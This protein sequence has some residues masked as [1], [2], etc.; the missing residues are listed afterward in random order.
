MKRRQF[1]GLAA[2]VGSTLA[3]AGCLGD[4]SN[5]DTGSDT[6]TGPTDDATATAPPSPTPTATPVDPGRGIYIQSFRERMSMQGTAASGDYEFALMFT[7]PHDFWTVTGDEVSETTIEDGDSVHLMAAVWDP[8]TGTVLPD[9][10]LSVEIA[11]D[12][13]LVSQE[14][15][16]PMLSQPMGFHY[17]GNFG[18]PGD[19]TYTVTLSVGGTNVRR[20]GAFEGRFGD[21]ATV[22]IPLEYTKRTR[23]EVRSRPLDRGGDPG[24]LRPMDMAVPQ[25]VLPPKSELP[26][27]VRASGRSDDAVFAV[28]T[29]E[30]GPVD[31]GTYLALSARTRYNRYVVPAMALDATLTR[32]SETVYEGPLRRTLDPYLGYH[33]GAAVDSVRSGDELTVSVV[34][35][36]QVARH[37]G[38]EAAFRQ[39]P[40]VSLTL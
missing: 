12:G 18:F 35:I 33:Y 4:S 1:V 21:P 7:V 31:G 13:E 27:T 8:E 20:T 17:G 15:I 9:T 30:E 26:G 5:S 3:L 14:V 16:Y 19:G 6:G 25:A 10:G 38:Y 2:G 37:E 29:L 23:E 39:M 32:D 36:P 24:A 40:D 34:T 11:R 28:T 22:E